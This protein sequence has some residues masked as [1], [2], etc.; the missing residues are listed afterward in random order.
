MRVYRS[1][2]RPANAYVNSRKKK[3]AEHV[4][5]NSEG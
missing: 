3:E 2:S 1:T 5:D 4:I